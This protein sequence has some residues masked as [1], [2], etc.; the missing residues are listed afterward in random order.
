MVIKRLLAFGVD[1]M[2][3]VAIVNVLFLSTLHN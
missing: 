2:I 1:L 3:I